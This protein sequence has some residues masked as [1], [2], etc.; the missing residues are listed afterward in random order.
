MLSKKCVYTFIFLSL[1]NRMLGVLPCSRALR[2]YVL[3]CSRAWCVCVLPCLV[4]LRVS[5]LTC[6]RASMLPC[7]RAW[8]AYVLACLSCLACLRA[9]RAHVL[10]VLCVLTCLLWWNVLLSSL[11]LCLAYSRFCLIIYFV[12]INQGFAIKRKLLIHVNLS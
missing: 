4:C 11:F 8:R 7:F 6:F 5:V 3:A 2:V 12:C 9:S 10:G 1:L